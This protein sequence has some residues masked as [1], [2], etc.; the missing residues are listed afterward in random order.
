MTNR[1]AA[2]QKHIPVPAGAVAEGWEV[3]GDRVT[4][5]LSIDHPPVSLVAIQNYDGRIEEAALVTDVSCLSLDAAEDLADRLP[6]I[7]GQLREWV[8]E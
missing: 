8:G 5:S 4:R 6:G 1:L 7:V 2:A 3:S